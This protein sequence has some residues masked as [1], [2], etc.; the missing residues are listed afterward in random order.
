MVASI[1]AASQFFQGASGPAVD[2]FISPTGNNANSGTSSGDAWADFTPVKTAAQAAG[3]GAT[4]SVR[5]LNGTYANKGPGSIG[6]NINNSVTLNIYMDSGVLFTGPTGVD[7]SW[8]DVT[9]GAG[10]SWTINL[11]PYIDPGPNIQTWTIQGY[12]TGTGNGIGMNVTSN[13][14]ILN[15]YNLLSQGNV[16]GWSCHGV[17]PQAN[18]YDSVFKS[19]SKSAASHVH[20]AGTM[21]AT[22]CEFWGNPGGSTLG[23]YFETVNAASLNTV[24]TNCKFIPTGTV[25]TEINCDFL[26]A[27]LQD[28]QIGTTTVKCTL[29]GS[30]GTNNITDSYINAAWDQNRAVN[31]LRC[32]GKAQIRMRNTAVPTVVD[33]CVFVDSPTG[34]AVDGFLWAN[35]DPGSM[36]QLTLSNTVFRG[37]SATAIGN[38]FTA[39]Y[40]GYWTTSSCALTNNDLFGNGTNIDADITTG[41]SGNITTDPQMPGPFNTV[42]QADYVVGAAGPCIGAGTAGSN[43]GFAATDI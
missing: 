23:I 12:D 9:Q 19:C 22:R 11:Q 15:V 34:A 14:A 33:H 8:I 1:F 18:I 36:G 30:T 27:T 43:I 40:G 21:K 31:M 32:Y 26:S 13:T 25:T 35:F 17:N 5:V 3:D 39:T 28:C 2:F 4:I 41:V 16:D 24:L 10:A 6:A 7:A 29:V 38:G 20:T 42:V 37:F